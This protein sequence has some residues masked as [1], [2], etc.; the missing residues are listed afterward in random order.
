[1]RRLTRLK[2]AIV[3]RGLKN[4]EVA[5]RAGDFLDP[6]ETLTEQAITR[7]ITG[8]MIASAAQRDAIARV[9]ECSEHDLFNT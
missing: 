5:E 1:M 2:L 3:E 8:R 7:I 4:Y 6:D 9:L